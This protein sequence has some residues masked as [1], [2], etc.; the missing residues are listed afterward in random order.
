[1]IIFRDEIP[2]LPNYMGKGWRPAP[3][4]HEDVRLS[5]SWPEAT[6]DVLLATFAGKIDAPTDFSATK[7]P[8]QP[9]YLFERR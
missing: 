4:T 8:A 6:D 3:R 1:M 5:A 2:R 7:G 9:K